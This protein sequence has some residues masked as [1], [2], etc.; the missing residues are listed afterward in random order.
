MSQD[1]SAYPAQTLHTDTTGEMRGWVHVV[2][3]GNGG[4]C[5][6]VP[7]YFCLPVAQ[8]TLRKGLR[9]LA[10]LPVRK[11]RVVGRPPEHAR[12]ARGFARRAARVRWCRSG[13]VA[14]EFDS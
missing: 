3:A 8:I 13:D 6:H 14:M 2:H 9:V 1:H 12:Q 7:A 10:S 11:V 5:T 4:A